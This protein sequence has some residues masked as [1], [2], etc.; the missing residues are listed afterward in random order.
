MAK[1]KSCGAAIEFVKMSGSL[2][3]MPVDRL[4]RPYWCPMPGDTVILK[5]VGKE[6]ITVKVPT[7]RPLVEVMVPH[8]ATCT[9]PSA[10]R[11]K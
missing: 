1:C 3:S 4:P 8:W 7:D 11:K 9:N 5:V 10:H 6:A 2:K